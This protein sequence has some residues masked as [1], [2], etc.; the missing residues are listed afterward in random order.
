MNITYHK[1]TIDDVFILVE[2]RIL[3]ALELA[4]PQNEE[5]IL[6]LRKQMTQYFSKAT[7]ENSCISFIAKCDGMVAGI[8]SCHLREMPGNFKNPSGKWGYIM[9]MYTVPKYRRMG[10][11]KGILNSLVE[12]GKK[13]GITAFDL[14]ATKEGEKV[15]VKEGFIH[16]IEPTLRK[17]IL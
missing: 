13:N 10:I 7:T 5:A 11:C 4:G 6:L 9:N 2:N 16:H 17:F 1:A 15:Y 8:G 12:E 3:F 14:H